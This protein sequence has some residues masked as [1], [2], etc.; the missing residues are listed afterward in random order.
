MLYNFI[1]V[2]IPVN[3][4]AIIVFIVPIR[5]SM[6]R[7]IQAQVS[8]VK[9]NYLNTGCRLPEISDNFKKFCIK[10]VL[11]CLIQYGTVI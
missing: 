9:F 11:Y 10:T 7:E 5:H 6:H 4:I 2:S 8:S 1:E 3:T